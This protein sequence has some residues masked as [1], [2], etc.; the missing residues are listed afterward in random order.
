M[1]SNNIGSCFF[2]SLSP[3]D[4]PNASRALTK[5]LILKP[6]SF[7]V[8]FW[9]TFLLADEVGRLMLTES[10]EWVSIC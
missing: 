8:W 5:K 4:H 9:P 2:L 6:E 1:E 7:T 3:K 10:L